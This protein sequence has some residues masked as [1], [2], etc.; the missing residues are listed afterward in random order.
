ME[1][2]NLPLSTPWGLSWTPISW[3][4]PRSDLPPRVTPPCSPAG[5]PRVHSICVTM[6]WPT[7]GSR[8]ERPRV[9][10]VLRSVRAACFRCRFLWL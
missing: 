6:T 9:R 10:S 5:V 3:G 8:G 7:G 2:V 4:I 1:G